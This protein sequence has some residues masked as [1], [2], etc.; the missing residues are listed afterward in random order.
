[1]VSFLSR[2]NSYLILSGLLAMLIGC[3]STS[4]DEGLSLPRDAGG[5]KVKLKIF[6]QYTID[7]DEKQP[8]D[9]AYARVK[10]LMPNVDLDI[11]VQPQD[12]SNKLKI[13]AA[14]GNLPDIIQ[15]TQGIV[16]LLRLSGN[17]LVLDDY[18]RQTRI[19]DRIIPNYRGLLWAD[20]GHSYA[21]PR[22][23]PSTHLLYY[24]KELFQ[25]NGIQVPKDYRKFIG[26]VKTFKA[27]GIIP[28]ALFAKES[29]PGVMLYEDFVTR[30]DPQ[31]LMKLSQGK[32]SITEEAYKKAAK[33]LEES[34][35]A[36]L[37]PN[38]AFTTDYDTAFNEFTN[39]KAAMFINGSWALGPLSDKMGE[40]VD[41]M[42]FPFADAEAVQ[43]TAMNRPGGGFDGGYSVSANTKYKDIAGRFTCLFALEIA[44]G[45]VVKAGMPN[46][47]TT[48]G[49]V[50]EKGYSAMS[51]KYIQ[52]SKNFNSTTVF[53]W[54]LNSKLAVIMGDSTAKLLTGGYSADRF[55]E[56]SDKAIKDALK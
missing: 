20:D 43:D 53:P 24:N 55:I 23:A 38:S 16:D 14:S 51:I 56:D 40:K 6:T 8:H 39:G 45:R 25:R 3:S 30:Y 31:G 41:F 33:Q 22:T 26:I 2:L 12:D 7:V 35:N 29:W 11:D 48:D 21:V 10:K 49:V 46:P 34:I 15:V 37:L 4:K 47:L 50:P 5:D 42:D 54:A 36:G 44:N 17:L 9:Y 13:Y 18:V 52:Q 28:L 32:G 27:K 19:E 1:M